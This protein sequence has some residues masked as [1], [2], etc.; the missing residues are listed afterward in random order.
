MG[1]NY[2]AF[3][4]LYCKYIIFIALIHREDAAIRS[5]SR[6]IGERDASGRENYHLLAAYIYI[7][8]RNECLPGEQCSLSRGTG[9]R[10]HAHARPRSFV[11]SAGRSG[12]PRRARV[13]CRPG[14]RQP[15]GSR[16][17][18]PGTRVYLSRNNIYEL[19]GMPLFRVCLSMTRTF[20]SI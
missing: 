17:I 4:S 20:V 6:G 5:R 15:R 2:I 7:I 18:A 12:A 14:A 10:G 9:L 8:R 16:Q 13:S 11:I 3:F 1:I 19:K